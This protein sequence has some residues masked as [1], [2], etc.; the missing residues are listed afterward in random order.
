MTDNDRIKPEH[1]ALL[2]LAETSSFKLMQ[3]SEELWL[4]VESMRR[5]LRR[6]ENTLRQ[7]LAKREADVRRDRLDEALVEPM[8][9]ELDVYL[10]E[11]RAL[12]ALLK[13]DDPALHDLCVRLRDDARLFPVVCVSEIEATSKTRRAKLAELVRDHE[14]N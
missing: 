11:S 14:C 1:E 4:R 12:E 3:T 6:R 8:R 10:R 5:V 7:Q 13:R 9:A 2:Y